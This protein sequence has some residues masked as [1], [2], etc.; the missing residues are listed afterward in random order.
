VHTGTVRIGYPKISF[1]SES[2]ETYVL[3]HEPEFLYFKT[4]MDITKELCW[5]GDI[6]LIEEET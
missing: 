3:L 1:S 4:I 6:P 5:Q 2:P